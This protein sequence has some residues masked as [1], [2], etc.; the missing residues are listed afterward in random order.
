MRDKSEAIAKEEEKKC[1]EINLRLPAPVFEKERDAA[2]TTTPLQAHT[3]YPNRLPA[4]VSASWLDLSFPAE[5][6]VEKG[7]T[8]P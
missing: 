3:P 1:V 6:T 7:S 8:G 2:T 4:K 5:A